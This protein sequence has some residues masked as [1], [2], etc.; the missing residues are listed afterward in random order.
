[1]GRI[2]KI[3]RELI[4]EANKKLLGEQEAN[5]LSDEIEDKILKVTYLSQRLQIVEDFINN[6]ITTISE[7]VESI[8]N[9]V[10]E[11]VDIDAE[12]T[13][14]SMKKMGSQVCEVVEEGGKK[15]KNNIDDDLDYLK[16]V[17]DI[18]IELNSPTSLSEDDDSNLPAVIPPSV[19]TTTDGDEDDIE[20]IEYEDVTDGTLALVPFELTTQGFTGIAQGVYSII[21]LTELVGEKM[22]NVGVA[23][24]TV[25]KI[26]K[27]ISHSMHYPTQKLK[28]SRKVY[29]YLG[30]Y[31]TQVNE[32]IG[33]INKYKN[34]PSKNKE[35]DDI[36]TLLTTKI[37][38]G[39]IPLLE[40]LM[41]PNSIDEP[42][43]EISLI[44][45][46]LRYI[47]KGEGDPTDFFEPDPERTPISPQEP[48][49]PE[50]AADLY[51]YA[52]DG[53]TFYYQSGG[54]DERGPFTVGD[55]EQMYLNNNISGE[56]LM[57]KSGS[58]QGWLPLKV[59]FEK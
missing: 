32:K 31:Y 8:R 33:L 7:D 54:G 42:Q 34:L 15:L 26:I 50:E 53:D 20:D 27:C 35:L 41:D 9:R 56:T 44:K 43:N 28:Q 36:I 48:E 30:A 21:K 6:F 18:M 14:K 25:R 24:N 1:M 51:F 52:N 5:P 47:F 12:P 57:W 2:A 59:M 49:A 13:S 11:Q 3:K 23:A 39:L 45:R 55:I 22:I 4:M 10:K 37:N 19:P 38:K 17:I 40:E 16:N 58:G 46:T 29:N